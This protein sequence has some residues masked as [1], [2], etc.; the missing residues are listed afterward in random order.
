MLLEETFFEVL[1]D[2]VVL[3]YSYRTTTNLKNADISL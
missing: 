2:A 3:N 1:E